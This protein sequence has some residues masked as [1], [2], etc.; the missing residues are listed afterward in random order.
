MVVEASPHAWGA[1]RFD[2]LK[3]GSAKRYR[4]TVKNWRA[5]A[6]KVA[7]RLPCTDG[8]VSPSGS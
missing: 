1:A 3:V 2:G 6:E 4:G 5:T 7:G 8:R